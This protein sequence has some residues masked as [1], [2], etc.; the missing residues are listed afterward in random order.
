MAMAGRKSRVRWDP[1]LA[2]RICE[3]LAAGEKWHV[4]CH[5]QEM[6]SYGTLYQWRDRRPEFA[7]EL[8]R[9]KDMA[10]D[11]NADEALV[12]AESATP[13]TVQVDRLKV[14]TLFKH[15]ALTAPHRWGGKAGSEPP[16][17]QKVRY[18]VKRFER[19]ILK[20][21]T[22]VIREAKPDWLK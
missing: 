11:R 7:E 3:R 5:E 9:A 14:S 13:P 21:G 2:E 1:K 6:P 16:P 19:V 4:F 10:A 17:P 12:V 22:T 18:Y 20:D 8:A 15:A